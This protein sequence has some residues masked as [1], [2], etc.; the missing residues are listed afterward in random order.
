MEAGARSVLVA[1][2]NLSFSGCAGAFR[3][4]SQRSGRVRP[5]RRGLRELWPTVRRSGPMRSALRA[6]LALPRLGVFLPG[7]RECGR[8]LL[9]QVAG[10][11]TYRDEL[12]RFG[13][14]RSGR[15]RAGRWTD[16]VLYRSHRRRLPAFRPAVRSDGE[17]LSNRL[18]SRGR[19]PR[20]DLS[21][22]RLW[23]PERHLLSQEPH[24]PPAA[25]AVLH[26]RRGAIIGSR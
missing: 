14:A 25:A 9:A 24:P 7:D 8:G 10:A 26:F 15:D 1:L 18:R 20:L 16:R 23:R 21:A 3:S 19:L 17:E 5:P 12:L 2:A 11:A 22:S 6:G 4:A 13:R